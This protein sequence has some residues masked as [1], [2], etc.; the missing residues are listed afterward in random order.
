VPEGD[1]AMKIYRIKTEWTKG[2]CAKDMGEAEKLYKA[3]YPEIKSIT[4]YLEYVVPPLW[5]IV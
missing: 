4:L 2:Y 1:R 3:E 5:I